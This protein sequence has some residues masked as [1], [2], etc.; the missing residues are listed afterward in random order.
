MTAR[1]VAGE[2]QVKGEVSS[3]SN[4]TP[5]L[6]RRRAMRHPLDLPKEGH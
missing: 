4:V 5:T 1:E 3:M 6:V 2:P